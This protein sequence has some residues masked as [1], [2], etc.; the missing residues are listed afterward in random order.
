LPPRSRSIGKIITPWLSVVLV[1]LCVGAVLGPP[2]AAADTAT[3]PEQPTATPTVCSAH[4]GAQPDTWMRDID[5]CIRYRRLTDIV[6]PGSHDSTT[7]GFNSGLAQT[8]SVDLI[9]QL[10]AGARQFDIRVRYVLGDANFPTGWYAF[11]GPLDN[12]QLTLNHIFND[13]VTWAAQDRPNRAQEIIMVNLTIDTNNSGKFPTDDCKDLAGALGGNL[14]TPDVLVNNFGTAD[15]GEVTFGQLWSLP[16]SSAGARMILDNTDCL[17]AAHGGFSQ[18]EWGPFLPAGQ[19][20]YSGY[21]ADQCTADGIVVPE[22]NQEPG[23]WALVMEAAEKPRATWG[24]GGPTPI[25]VGPSKVGGLH[26]LSIQGTP[27]FGCLYTPL[28]MVPDEHTVF[29]RLTNLWYNSGVGQ[30]KHL[31]VVAGDFIDGTWLWVPIVNMNVVLAP[32]DPPTITG[33]TSGPGQVSIAFS[34]SADQGTAPVTSYTVVVVPSYQRI[35]GTSSPI[36]VTGLTNGQEYVFAMSAT[37]AVG[38]GEQ[39]GYSNSITVGGSP[40]TLD[41]GPAYKGFVGKSYLSRFAVRGMRGTTVTLV[42]GRIPPGLTLGNDGTLAGTPT[43]AGE[44]EFG[45]RATN[46]FGS[47]AGVA[48]LVISDPG[49]T[50]APHPETSWQPMRANICTTRAKDT[51]ECASRLL[52]GPFPQLEDRAAVS[53]VRGPVTYATGHVTGDGRLTLR[54]EQPTTGHYTLVIRDHRSTFVP[55]TV[56]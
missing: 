5:P 6:I 28:A 46:R 3:P 7:Y 36:T 17:T 37:S 47:H 56:H 42:S 43:Q 34:A 14:V 27:E 51:P 32:P 24:P 10:N 55:V 50:G 23:I 11:H 54:G 15:P 20:L 52:F 22:N 18:G 33:L 9:G 53:L 26:V 31:N 21:Y 40:P 29:T 30:V 12:V 38:T 16:T 41:D 13:L 45:V 44:Y 48:Q 25:T 2:H 1:A 19:T 39:G 8:Q 49:T 35:T 4:M